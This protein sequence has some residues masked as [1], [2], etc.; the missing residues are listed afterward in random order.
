MV[1]E[2]NLPGCFGGDQVVLQPGSLNRIAPPPVRLVVVAVED[3]E[4]HGA[5]LKVVIAFIP[6][7]GEIIQVR[8]DMAWIPVVVAQGREEAIFSGT[9]AIGAFVGMDICLVLLTD[10]GVDGAGFAVWVVVIADGDDKV[11]VPTVN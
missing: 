8:L 4:M 3:E 6:G 2:Y 7:Q 1:Q 5:A 11:N 9:G 10:V